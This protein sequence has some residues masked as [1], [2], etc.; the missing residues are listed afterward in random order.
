MSGP[1][2][3]RL[4]KA[5]AT[6]VVVSG[7]IAINAPTIVSAAKDAL[8]D[9][10]IN[11]AGY[12]EAHGHW[13]M[14]D[15]PDDLRVNAIH[16]ALLRTGKVL[17]IAG[18]GNDQKQFDAGKFKTLLWNP[19]TDKFKLIHT[20]SDMFCAGHVFLPDGKLLIA[21]G[22]RRYEKLAAD[23]THAA[24]VMTIKDESPDGGPLRLP[25]G[26]KLHSADGRS[27]HTTKQVVVEPASKT[28]A[29]DGTAKV[30]ASS[31]EVWVEADEP[32]KASVVDESTQFAIEGVKRD[33]DELYG[34]SQSLTRAKQDYWGDDK[35]Y[36]FDPETEKY[37]RVDNMTLAR[38]YPTLVGL[39]DGR[40][41]SVSGLDDFGRMIQGANEIYDPATKQWTAQP[42]LKRTFP[43]YPALFLM[44]SGK[45]FYT[46]SNAG[47][48]S[49]TVGRAPGIWDLSDNSFEKVP[50]LR[51]PRQTETSGS[52]LLPP[53]QDQRYMIAGGGGIGESKR[54][55]DRT[56]VID[57]NSAHPRFTAGP[58]LEKPVRYPN[59]VITPDD[60][61]V[62]TGGSTGY[63]GKGNSDVLLCH[64]YDPRTNRLTRMADPAVGRDYHSEALLLPDG[65][66]ITMGSNPLFANADDTIPAKFEQRIEIY[67][68]P[69]LFQGDRP[70]VTGG[71]VSVKRGDTVWFGT[72][73]ARAIK[74]ARLVR[75][76][77]VTH[78]TDVEQ[79]SIKLDFIP[80]GDGIDAT[81]PSN[82]GL[83][84]SGWYMLFVTDGN[85]APSKAHWVEVK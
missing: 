45:L 77:A 24:G 10:K 16:A 82:A 73:N 43:T 6:S 64:L 50:G 30:T 8:H 4:L 60:K 66:V 12:K 26:T 42:Q 74:S 20:P 15:V 75:P 68:P 5:L 11:S 51:D 62:I 44:P 29:A 17:I 25:K 79:R 32:G 28:I 56:D 63:R 85:G 72:S 13:S 61:V 49:D 70:D 53:A 67:S 3:Q 78:V 69:Y 80:N 71:P 38:W 34:Y 57:L 76:S 18:S 9:Y 47:Y 84:P 46:G 19:D 21:G 52:V 36:L 31:V 1:R 35:S 23:I 27:F 54:S 40:V 22:T 59:M 14:L 7:L 2:R 81:I 83:L 39:K 37:E 55:T 41:L 33:R 48:G 65:R 58:D